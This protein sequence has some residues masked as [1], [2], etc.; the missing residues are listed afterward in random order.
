MN[1]K[2]RFCKISNKG[3]LPG[4]SYCMKENSLSLIKIRLLV[5]NAAYPIH[6]ANPYKIISFPIPSKFVCNIV[7]PNCLC[8]NGV[9]GR[10]CRGRGQNS[11]DTVAPKYKVFSS[12]HPSFFFCFFF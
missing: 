5:L 3:S 8:I 12:P 7:S 1:T 10:H 6:C 11:L 4:N 9:V 2:C